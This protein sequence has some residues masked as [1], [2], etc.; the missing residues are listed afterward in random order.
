MISY[1]TAYLKAHYPTEFMAALLTSEKANRDKIIDHISSCK[2]MGVNV[3]PPD[4]NES[5]SDFSVV[6]ENIRFGL[7]A[8]KNVGVG[9]IESIITVREKDGPF[10]SIVDF[11]ERVDPRK[12]NK[13]VIESLIKC[14]TFDS[15]GNKRRQL[16]AC[17]EDLMEKVQRRQRERSSGQANFLEQF[18]MNG[19]PS[20]G[21]MDFA[22][23]D[24]PEWDHKELLINE[25]ET[26]GFYITGHPLSRF[27]DV[28]GLIVNADSSNLSGKP[29]REAVTLAGIVGNIREVTTRRKEIMA[30]VTL[31]DLKGS[32]NMIFFPDT[33]RSAYELL[34]G[35]EPLLIKGT[36]DI[37]EDSTKVIAAE[38]TLL[39]SAV[40]KS[41][42]A[43]YFTIDV[44]KS[45]AEDI[46]IL[47]QQL[48]QYPGKYDGF[49]KLI[50]KKSETVIYL[51]ENIKLDLSL[52]LR[53]EADRI[54]GIGAAQFV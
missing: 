16:M 37:A 43:V 21:S 25:K 34:H 7:A 23:P 24:I 38:V 36:L 6:G 44:E 53:K 1:Q 31:E 42:R 48:K 5:H 20:S 19:E 39:A 14:G 46:A 40:E 3:L 8:V 29:D 32:A 35:E 51:G 50:D 10:R 2:E 45:S 9:A 22:L 12:V 11:C 28:M 4:I 49:I 47:G 30:Y 27:A 13:R 33:Y 52:P 18:E 15:T 54:L 26:I 41:H 17:Y